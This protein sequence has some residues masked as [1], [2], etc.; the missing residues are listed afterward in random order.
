MISDGFTTP[1]RDDVQRPFPSTDF[2][3]WTPVSLLSLFSLH[4]VNIKKPQ[5]RRMY[6]GGAGRP[7][8]TLVQRGAAGVAHAYCIALCGC[9]EY[10]RWY[11]CRVFNWKTKETNSLSS[12]SVL[13]DGG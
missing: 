6:C 10:D 1:Q 12:L 3:P 2:H 9:K 7:S 5:Q 11:V 13:L 4:F 8:L